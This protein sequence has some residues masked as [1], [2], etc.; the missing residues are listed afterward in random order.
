VLGYTD[1]DGRGQ[2]GIEAFF[3]ERLSRSGRPLTLS[4]DSRVQHLL[5]EEISAAMKT[6]RAIGAAG[7]VLDARSGEILAMASLP[8][9]DP[10]VRGDPGE[11]ERFN[12]AAQG[13]YELGSVFKIFTTALALDSHTVT[14][15]DGYDTS[16]PLRAARF[17]IRDYKPKNRWLSVPEI[18]IYSSNIG[19]ARMAMDTGTAAQRAFLSDLG[20]TYPAPLELPEIAAPMLPR[21]W[22]EISTMT[23][24]YGHGL[25]VSP[26]QLASAVAAIVNSGQ[27]HAPTLLAREPGA[28]SAPRQVIDP[29][30][31]R[32]MR[33]LMRLVVRHGTGRKANA[34]GYL[35]GGKTGTADKASKWGGYRKKANIAS[36]VG[37]FPMD[38]PRY[39]IFVMLDEPKGTKETYNYA[40]GGWVAAPAV[41]RIIQRMAPL[42]GIEPVEETAE[43]EAGER[44]LKR[45]AAKVKHLA[46]R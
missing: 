38:A 44:L 46:S 19:T 34:E 23:I 42:L 25:S 31:S 39:V 40:T 6:F 28:S 30:T 27:H 41:R 16:K 1:V 43:D 17:T 36:F 45:A 21:S 15:R 12:R 3:D 5:G 7:I 8:D 4:L 37:A 10:E 11:D 32:T 2:A 22:G 29:K 35:V 26:V 33:R 14:L 18:F 13:V 20:L 9:F 24:S